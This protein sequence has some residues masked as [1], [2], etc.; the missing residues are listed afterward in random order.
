MN[1]FTFMYCKYLFYF[2]AI[3]ADVNCEISTD[4]REV[5]I[6]LERIIANGWGFENYFKK[7][8]ISGIN[9]SLSLI[10]T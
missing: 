7:T 10:V 3:V 9:N 5:Y 8:D 1:L 6:Y 2:H 4:S